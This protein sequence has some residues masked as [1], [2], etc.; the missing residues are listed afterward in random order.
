M[1]DSIKAFLHCLHSSSFFFLFLSS[2][3]SNC[4]RKLS[5]VV[6]LPSNV[7]FRAGENSDNRC[8]RSPTTETTEYH[9]GFRSLRN[10]E[11][12]TLTCM[13]MDQLVSGTAS[14]QQILCNRLLSILQNRSL[15]A[16]LVFRP[17]HIDGHKSVKC[18]MSQ[19]L[20]ISEN[21]MFQ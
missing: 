20:K 12:N 16:C 21:G 17:R 4:Y 14:Q 5:A 1:H 2:A 9:G 15:I 3:R 13:H 8:Q 7:I 19:I 10:C 11:F 6:P 18:R